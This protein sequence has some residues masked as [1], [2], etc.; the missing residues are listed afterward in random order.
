[1]KIYLVGIGEHGLLGIVVAWLALGMLCGC[2]LQ[3]A[4]TPII[5]PTPPPICYAVLQDVQQGSNYVFV[6]T[7][8]CSVTNLPCQCE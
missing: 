8:D 7:P 5:P 1:M 4:P 6:V 2:S 3:I